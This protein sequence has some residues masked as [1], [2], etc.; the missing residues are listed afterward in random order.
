MPTIFAGYHLISLLDY[1][2]IRWQL[3]C[4]LSGCRHL[5]VGLAFVRLC[6]LMCDGVFAGGVRGA[7][8]ICLVRLVHS[9]GAV[10]QFATHRFPLCILASLLPPDKVPYRQTIVEI[11]LISIKLY[12]IADGNW[13][14]YRDDWASWRCQMCTVVYACVTYL[15]KADS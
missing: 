3:I 2:V 1:L 12:Y 10:G 5:I 7:G 15:G 9:S 8:G 11:A 14:G 4:I 6:R 13:V